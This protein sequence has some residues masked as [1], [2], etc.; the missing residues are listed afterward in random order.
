MLT[1]DE[2][3]ISYRADSSL[4]GLVS[5]ETQQFFRNQE[6]A[7]FL[8]DRYVPDRY[9][10]YEDTPRFDDEKF[11]RSMR[12]IMA[13]GVLSELDLIKTRLLGVDSELHATVDR[14][15]AETE[16][17]LAVI[18]PILVIATILSVTVNWLW[19][20]AILPLCLYL[21]QAAVRDRE[22][23]DLLVD[24]L[25]LGRVKAPS[26]ER[27]QRLFQQEQ[28]TKERSKTGC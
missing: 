12:G 10:S 13:R 19:A 7:E 17:R 25:Y 20:I 28:D 8:D 15:Q 2:G 22:A 1:R 5:E 16:F 11:Q 9:L 18:P 26:L 3:P 4:W 27:L 23:K 6:G 14:L 24:A 21:T